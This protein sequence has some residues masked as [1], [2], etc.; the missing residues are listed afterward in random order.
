MTKMRIGFLQYD[1]KFADKAENKR[2]IALL[3][4]DR[5]FD[6][7]VLPELALTGYVMSSRERTAELA[8][9]FPTGETFDFFRSVA[10][11]GNGAVVFGFAERS[12]TKVFN[13]AALVLPD[14]TSFLYRKTHLFFLEKKWYDPGDTGFNVFEFR[15]VTIGIMIC[16][17][18][19]FPEAART[20]MLRGAEVICHPANL[21]L[22]YCQDAMVTRCLENRVFAITCNRT[23]MEQLGQEKLTFTGRSQIVSPRGEVLVRAAG[24]GDS[25]ELIE[26]DPQIAQDKAVTPHNDLIDDRRDNFYN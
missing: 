12:D 22:P 20:L 13:A 6:L 5:Q 19:Y 2:R 17:D 15:G 16:F 25:L 7:L 14:G 4:G 24:T 1:I 3:L 9:E 26:I 21:V 11:R 10:R 23:G 8:E 18:W